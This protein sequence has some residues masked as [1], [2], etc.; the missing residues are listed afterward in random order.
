MY[1]AAAYK[2]WGNGLDMARI[3]RD[4][5][6]NDYSSIPLL[7]NPIDLPTDDDSGSEQDD[8]T[9]GNYVKSS[10]RKCPHKHHNVDPASRSQTTH[11]HNES[12]D[13]NDNNPASEFQS[14]R[15]SGHQGS[16]IQAMDNMNTLMMYMSGT[17]PEARAAYWQKEEE[18]K[19]LKEKE[20][21]ENK[22]LEWLT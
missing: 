13:P 16:M 5:F 8:P 1:G 3:L 17:S 19:Q 11:P 10:P 15:A 6:V 20:T 12:K 4:T 9:D 22:V 2:C 7:Q 21:S 14:N 18:K